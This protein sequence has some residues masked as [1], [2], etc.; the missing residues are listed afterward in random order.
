MP[1][2]SVPPVCLKSL[3]DAHCGGRLKA[4]LVAPHTISTDRSPRSSAGHPASLPITERAQS[5][6]TD[7]RLT[8]ASRLCLLVVAAWTG[9]AASQDTDYCKFTSE[10]TVCKFSGRGPRCGPQVRGSGVSSEDAAVIVALHNELRS[11]VARGEETRGAP[12][13]QP[14][15]ANMK[16]LRNSARKMKL[17]TV[18]LK[19]AV[20]CS[21]PHCVCT[22]VSRQAWDEELAAVAQ[23][24]ADQCVFEHEC[25]DCRRVDRFGVGQNL[26]IS[27][28]SNLDLRIQWSRAI[29][30]W[31]DEVADFPNT[32]IHPYQFS[33]ATGHYTQMLWWDTALIGCGFT[34]FLEDGWWKKLY[35]CN[36][37]PAGNIIFS[38]MYLRGAPCSACPDGTFCSLQYPGLCEGD[39][40]V[41][42]T[43]VASSTVLPPTPAKD[44]INTILGDFKG[45]TGLINLNSITPNDVDLQALVEF[46]NNMR[47][48][49]LITVSATTPLSGQTATTTP[50]TTV[51]PSTETAAPTTVEPATTTI[52][53][54]T[55][56]PLEFL[57]VITKSPISTS[58]APITTVPP[59]PQDE[60][61]APPVTSQ[62]ASPSP[63]LS[64]EP[65]A[66]Q[67]MSVLE[68][69]RASEEGTHMETSEHNNLG[70]SLMSIL[71]RAGRNT[72]VIRTSSLNN[73][74]DIIQGLPTGVDPIV[75]LRSRNGRL[76]ELD[77]MSLTPR[78]A[79]RSATNPA[80]LLTCDMDMSPCT[81]SLA[82][83]SWTVMKS[84]GEWAA[85]FVLYE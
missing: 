14:S 16:A 72:Q 22:C 83:G 17:R 61:V 32:S 19:T 23:R 29:L 57:S 84:T 46:F 62:V 43:S 37:G 51:Q 20:C 1:R 73:V 68:A 15:G 50:T 8:M 71:L 38:Q 7:L 42:N 18:R 6:Q 76:T 58:L 49:N 67:I 40:D 44:D 33:Q 34:M 10:H 41:N 48:N 85:L 39:V 28:Q 66:E 82:G 47:R 55:E 64:V 24:H 25:P 9:L 75:V 74:H 65:E 70:L 26:F 36:Y 81:M 13:P 78:R 56:Q 77:P 5:S 2:V 60:T 3:F 12:G 30:S 59:P 53:A 27:F 31:Y 45:F 69:L 21:F 54:A 11:K 52:T 35:T 4:S 63:M 80:R 79:H